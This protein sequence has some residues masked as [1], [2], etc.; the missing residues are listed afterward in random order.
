MIAE[1]PFGKRAGFDG[2]GLSAASA[3]CCAFF[4]AERTLAI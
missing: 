3:P 2:R 1:W 4:A